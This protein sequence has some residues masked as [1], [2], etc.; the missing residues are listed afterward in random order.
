VLA[1]HNRYLRADGMLGKTPWWNFVDWP[2]QWNWDNEKRIGGVPSLDSE[3]RSS[4]LSLQLVYALR[5]AADL[6]GK[7]GK[8]E[9]A[10]QYQ[11][12]AEKIRQATV[13][14]CWDEKRRLLADTPDKTVFSQHANTLAVLVDAVPVESQRDLMERV[15]AH[16]SLVQCTM[17]YRF[18]LFRAMKKAGLGDRYIEMLKPWR[19]MLA[20][21]LTTFAERP[22]P[23]RSDCHAWSASPN[24]DLL[25]SVCGIEPSSSSFRRV[26]IEPHLGPL[27]WV[28]G[29][30][31]H[32]KGTIEVRLTR[33]NASGL[34]GEISLPAT[35]SGELIWRGKTQKLVPGV[36]KVLF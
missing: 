8:P 13:K 16:A 14:Y 33:K 29:R 17:Y 7:E 31:P 28:E 20:L 3:G 2:D 25:A 35:V 30:M 26:R 36:H 18:Y 21:G 15:A 22:E 9:L 23:T 11:A 24:Y 10:R 5:L 19:D 32:P 12:V 27:E 1:W 6:L 34:E 4:I